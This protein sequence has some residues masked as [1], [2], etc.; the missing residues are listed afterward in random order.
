MSGNLSY[1]APHLRWTGPMAIGDKVTLVFPVHLAGTGSGGAIRNVAWA[2]ANPAEPG[3]PTAP[4]CDGP[5]HYD[6]TTG[7]PCAVSERGRALVSVA[8]TVSAEP[9][10]SRPG[11]RVEYTLTMTNVGDVD[12]DVTHP[13][14]VADDLA[15]VLG[16]ATFALTDARTE[17]PGQGTIAWNPATALLTWTGPLAHGAAGAITLVYTVTLTGSG[18]GSF[19]N[20]V[21][22]PN[23]PAVLKPPDCLRRMGDG[24]RL[25]DIAT[26]EACAVTTYDYPQVRLTKSV[27]PSGPAAPGD[28]RTYTV[29]ATNVGNAAYTDA[30]PAIVWDA[31]ASLVDDATYQVGSATATY[32]NDDGSTTP[33]TAPSII[34]PPATLLTWSGPLAANQTV[35]ISYQVRL[36]SSGPGDVKNTAWSPRDPAILDPANPHAVP[37]PACRDTSPADGRDDD[38]HEP[39]AI[40][41]YTLPRLI[42]TKAHTGGPTSRPGDTIAYTITAENRGL[43]DFTPLSEAM[44]VDSLTDVL[45]D[46]AYNADATASSHAGNLAWDPGAQ[47]LSWHGPLA[48]GDKVT[49]TY[50]VTLTGGGNGTL[51]N[52]VW[53]PDDPA[54][55]PPACTTPTTQTCAWDTFDRAMLTVSKHVLGFTKGPDGSINAAAGS[56]VRYRIA[57]TNVGAVP[58]TQAAPA[59]VVDTSAD[60]AG[61]AAFGQAEDDDGDP[62]TN[63][64]YTS[65]Y[66]RW[67]GP[68]A[69]GAT[70]QITYS[71]RLD[72]RGNGE[73]TNVAWWPVNPLASNPQAPACAVTDPQDPYSGAGIDLVTRE[74][75]AWDYWRRPMVM[76]EKRIVTPGPYVPGMNVRFEVLATN[77]SEVPYTATNPAW[78]VDDLSS[79]LPGIAFTGKIAVDPPTAPPATYRAPLIQWSGPVGKGETIRLTYSVTLGTAG[80]G[81][82]RNVVWRPGTD[83]PGAPPDCAGDAVRVDPLTGESCRSVSFDKPSLAVTKTATSVADDGTVTYVIAATNPGP[84]TF[85]ANRPAVVADD[86]SALATHGTYLGDARAD[87]PGAIVL[88]GGTMLTWTGPLDAGATITITYSVALHAGATTLRNVAWAPNNPANPVVPACQDSAGG[89]VVAGADAATAEACATAVVDSPGVK[90]TKT[91]D[92]TAASRPGDVVTYTLT[93]ENAGTVGFTAGNPAVVADNLAGVLDDAEWLSAASATSG[94]VTLTGTTVTWSGPLAAHGRVSVTYTVRLTQ[95]GDG[96]VANVAWVPIDPLQPVPPS[97]TG[98]SGPHRDPVSGEWCDRADFGRPVLTVAKRT[99]GTAS[100]L[101]GDRVTYHI[102]VTNRGP[103]SFTSALPAVVVDDLSGVLDGAHLVPGSLS[104][105]KAGGAFAIGPDSTVTWRGPVPAGRTV[106]LHL[107]VILDD[108]VSARS[109][110]VAWSPRDPA[111]PSAPRCDTPPG[112][113]DTVTGEPCATTTFPRAAR[114]QISKSVGGPAERRIGDTVTYTVTL[115]HTEGAA[116]TVSKPLTVLD[117]LTGTVDD[118]VYNADPSDGG[119]GGTFSFGHGRL[120]WSG[121]LSEGGTVRLTYSVT[122]TG[123]GDLAVQNTA[124]VPAGAGDG[125][126]PTCPAGPMTIGALAPSGEPCARVSFGLPRLAVS[127]SVDPAGA[128]EAGGTIRY[129]IAVTNTGTAPFTATAPAEITDSIAGLVA[130]ATWNGDLLAT[131]GTTAWSSPVARWRGAL[132]AGQSAVISYSL[133]VGTGALGTLVNTACAT[134]PAGGACSQARLGIPTLAI[135]KRT[136]SER[137]D[138]IGRTVTFEVTATNTGAADFTAAHPAEIRDTLTDVLDDATFDVRSVSAIVGTT[139]AGTVHPLRR[140]VLRWTGPLAVGQ[141]VTLTYSVAYEGRGNHTLA[142]TACAPRATAAGPACATVAVPGPAIRHTKR[143]ELSTPAPQ[144]GTVI[145]YTVHLV[146]AGDAP[147]VLNL[148]DPLADVLDDATWVSRPSALPV[149]GGEAAV[150]NSAVT[151]RVA[152]AVLAVTG[153]LGPHTSVDV[154][155][156]VKVHNGGDGEILNYLVARTRRGTIPPPPSA[157]QCLQGTMYPDNCVLL[158]RQDHPRL[159]SE[160]VAT[161]LPTRTGHLIATILALLAVGVAL[162]AAGRRRH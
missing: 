18:N 157:T 46:A 63:P 38:T 152:G 36:N 19:R 78:L 61:G 135:A 48:V 33:G 37:P 159:P 96:V 132:A 68:L 151:A 91:T 43:A 143:A 15:G 103:A 89:R 105:G 118:A 59:Y 107:T 72:A 106:A 44:I 90:V 122:L 124:W 117:D 121:P 100:S 88:T 86:L 51:S 83:T 84:G 150:A 8:K 111:H 10:L 149:R 53:R 39:C 74:A 57:V 17:P 75:C 2:P 1:A 71:V 146:N 52:T 161:G 158:R 116:F 42:L 70:V 108:P 50:S 4:A 23:D 134:A 109:H 92:G 125:T 40:V 123:N 14:V 115:R 45:D 129:R 35:R 9:A 94:T 6:P 144:P 65:P 128:V 58:F 62:A 81:S 31:L 93:I 41:Q 104:D 95:G 126:T 85:D 55:P 139:R 26:G 12:H 142:N 25:W 54:E 114:V 82:T 47:R 34:P 49:I 64:I 87:G 69:A 67:S 60:L 156:R 32:V 102:D 120:R 133:T 29:T 56:W 141:R 113:V 145:T 73:S 11:A 160:T 20:T 21:W 28:L 140:G 136:V 154:V 137:P 148:A 147:G 138:R 79:L 5:T 76:F 3:G 22:V 130:S 101:P 98:S 13:A 97:C 119:V 162:I 99:D 30:D 66:L 155:Y 127:K 7:E 110:N 24:S 16:G 27:D 80:P 153:R 77:I 112:G 131:H